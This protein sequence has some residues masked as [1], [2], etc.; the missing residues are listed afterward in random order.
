MKFGLYAPENLTA[1]KLPVL[2]WL[3]GLTCTHENFTTKAGFQKWASE[4]K[5]IVVAPDTSPRGCGIEGEAD[6][7][8]FGVG[9]GFYIDATEPKWKTNFR[10]FSYVNFELHDV[11][12]EIFNLTPQELKISISGHSMG[13]HGALISFLKT[14]S[15]YKSVSAFA[16]ICNPCACDWGKFA[17]TGYFGD[18]QQKWK[19]ND[20]THLIAQYKRQACTILI[21]QGSADNFLKQNQ[22]N[23][24][25]LKTSET[26]LASVDLRMQEGYDH[27]YYFIST[28]MEDHFK[29][30][31]KHLKA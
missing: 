20:A 4:H 18:D 17:F 28:F 14:D 5:I 3:S 15:K 21:D 30:H 7:W 2:I 27:S 22:L 13:G 25:N 12:R 10:M 1:E 16:P 26:T 9:A 19:E 24:D 31:A 23:P 8:D 6:R 11:I 29:F